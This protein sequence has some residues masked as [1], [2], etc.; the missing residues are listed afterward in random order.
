[1]CDACFQMEE[2]SQPLSESISV[3]SAA[4]MF[5]GQAIIRRIP[6]PRNSCTIPKQTPPKIPAKP[7]LIKSHTLDATAQVQD[8]FDTDKAMKCDN[9]FAMDV[10]ETGSESNKDV[11]DKP[12]ESLSEINGVSDDEF[13]TYDNVNDNENIPSYEQFIAGANTLLDPDHENEDS[14]LDNVKIPD[15]IQTLEMPK[16]VKNHV[17][18]YAVMD[19]TVLGTISPL[20]DKSCDKNQEMSFV[21]GRPPSSSL[22]GS[23][24]RI[25][26]CLSP[27]SDHQPL[28]PSN[29][30]MPSKKV[31]SG[32]HGNKIRPQADVSPMPRGQGMSQK[33]KEISNPPGIMC[34]GCNN[35]LVDFKRQVLRMVYPDNSAN[36]VPMVSS[37][38]QTREPLE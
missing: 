8:S 16:P 1:M 24:S 5:G 26:R 37:F 19:Y 3:K 9:Q 22:P 32:N 18:D 31:T 27:Q 38:P 12:L 36:P 17:K 25:K 20:N 14:E 33:E 30:L 34:E 7:I 23:E 13:E 28:L 11:L 2:G 15:T 10:T 29:S 35:C 21:L 4:N 6:T